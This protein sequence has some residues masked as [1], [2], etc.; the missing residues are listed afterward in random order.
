VILFST[1]D[2]RA[3]PTDLTMTIDGETVF[4]NDPD[5]EPS[6]AVTEPIWA[7]VIAPGQAGPHVDDLMVIMAPEESGEFEITLS[8]G[9]ES[10]TVTV[11]DDG[12]GGSLVWATADDASGGLLA[13]LGVE[14][15]IS[16]LDA[17][18]ASATPAG[19]ADPDTTTSVPAMPAT[20]A[21]G[22]AEASATTAV[23][24]DDAPDTTTST[25]TADHADPVAPATTVPTTHSAEPPPTTIITPPTT[26]R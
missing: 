23:P 7:L 12:V 1:I 18:C 10:G 2:G 5:V 25:V 20:T 14:V 4:S 11:H 9:G 26:D 6:P 15:A 24:A 19:D 17:L 8:A 16:P 21:P 3:L 13:S 22:S